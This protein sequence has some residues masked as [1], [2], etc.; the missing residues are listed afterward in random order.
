M[1]SALAVA[2]A[3]LVALGPG[4]TGQAGARDGTAAPPSHRQGAEPSRLVRAPVR[5][6]DAG[7]VRLL[8]PGD[9]VNVIATSGQA[10]RS[11]SIGGQSDGGVTGPRSVAESV[12]VLEVPEPGDGLG[13][14]GSGVAGSPGDGALIVLSVPRSDAVALAGAAADTRLAVTLC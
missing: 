11:P 5:I 3:A 10:A 14:G 12:R 1:A 6:A 7:A 9:R 13:A 4:D 2:A 8:R